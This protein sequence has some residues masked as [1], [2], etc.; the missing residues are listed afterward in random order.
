MKLI[1]RY[2]RQADELERLVQQIPAAGILRP[3][4][5]GEWSVH[6][7][8]AHIRDVEVRAYQMRLERILRQDNPLF[9]D[10]DAEGWMRLHYR[11]SEPVQAVLESFAA[12]RRRGKML[13]VEMRADDWQRIGTHPETGPRSFEW[14][15]TRSVEHAQEH[16]DELAR[17]RES[18]EQED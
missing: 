12:A 18:L 5:P 13:V 6:Q 15:M 16:L 4:K 7:V 17:R 2:V 11:E 10:F 3:P 14:W 1:E 9:E 8:L